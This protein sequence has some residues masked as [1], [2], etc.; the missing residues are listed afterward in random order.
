MNDPHVVSLRYLL[1]PAPDITYDAPLPVEVSQEEFDFR[2]SD[3]V[4]VVRLRG[5]FAVE[6]DARKAVEPFLRAYEL[7]AA[8]ID[9]AMRF[10]LKFDTAEMVDRCPPPPGDP[11]VIEVADT[12]SLSFSDT[13][14]VGRRCIYPKYPEPP[15]AFRV[16]P[17]VETMWQRY[18]GWKAGRE[19]LTNMAYFCLTFVEKIAFDDRKDAAAH[20]KISAN[21]LQK[22]RYLANVGD[23]QSARK[24][25]IQELRPHSTAETEWMDHAV[26][27]LIRRMAQ[28]S[29]NPAFPGEAITLADLPSLDQP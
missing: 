11:R 23:L 17:D 20:L 27:V 28:Y 25:D 5:H 16:S 14:L 24:A 15:T 13:C 29:F 12:E 21:V 6:A 10:T 8:L 22:L 19:L 26:R 9:G 18:E 7:H 1:V 2:L 4:A 3:G